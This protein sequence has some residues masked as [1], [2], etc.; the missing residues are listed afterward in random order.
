[1]TGRG[2][3]FASGQGS[4]TRATFL[5]MLQGQERL[6]AKGKTDA[7][8]PASPSRALLQHQ[9]RLVGLHKKLGG[10][11]HTPKAVGYTS[12][13]RPIRASLSLQIA[14]DHSSWRPFCRSPPGSSLSRG[15]SA[16][17]T[18]QLWSPPNPLSFTTLLLRPHIAAPS[19]SHSNHLVSSTS[20]STLPSVSHLHHLPSPPHHTSPI[21]TIAI[22]SSSA[23]SRPRQ[24]QVACSSSVRLSDR[25]RI[26]QTSTY[27]HY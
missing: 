20:S 18:R 15:R 14:R 19:L 1:M 2:V 27:S 3:S 7:P 24:L 11:T 12:R 25:L 5:P 4:S 23:L 8:L 21:A 22:T 10:P 26:T 17:L 9:L 13:A 16:E 6:P